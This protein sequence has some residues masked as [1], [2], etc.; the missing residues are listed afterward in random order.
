MIAEG[1]LLV[2][3]ESALL[4]RLHSQLEALDHV[5][6][7]WFPALGRFSAVTVLEMRK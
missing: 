7:R 6:L 4:G 5:L 3:P 2:A 1:L